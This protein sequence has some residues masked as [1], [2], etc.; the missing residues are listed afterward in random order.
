VAGVLDINSDS[1]VPFAILFTNKEDEVV[2]DI[3]EKHGEIRREIVAEVYGERYSLNV[4]NGKS[5]V[6]YRQAA[7]EEVSHGENSMG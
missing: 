6:M 1:D 2:N 3:Y 4:A 7:E 5:V